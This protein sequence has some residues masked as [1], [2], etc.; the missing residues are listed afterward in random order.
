MTPGPSNFFLYVLTNLRSRFALDRRFDGFD[1][2][3]WFD[4]CLLE[5]PSLAYT[6]DMGM[7]WSSTALSF[8]RCM[9]YKCVK[10]ATLVRLSD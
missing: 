10:A 9:W 8:E 7:V 6:V 2:G 3:G 1:K 5:I 4:H